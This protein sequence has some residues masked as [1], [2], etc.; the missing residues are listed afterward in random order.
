MLFNNNGFTFEWLVNMN[1]R[2]VIQI[3]A[4]SVPHKLQAFNVIP[5]ISFA[6]KHKHLNTWKYSWK[7]KYL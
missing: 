2:N 4:A 1:F 6:S 5:V 7:K 3:L